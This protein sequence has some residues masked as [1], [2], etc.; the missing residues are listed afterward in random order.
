MTVTRNVSNLSRGIGELLEQRFTGEIVI[1]Q[2]ESRV[3]IYLSKEKLLWVQDKRHFRRRWHRALNKHCAE[4][5]STQALAL[6][7]ELDNYQQLSQAVARQEIRQNQVQAA[8]AEVATECLFELFI[9]QSIAQKLMWMI[10]QNNRLEDAANLGLSSEETKAIILQADLAGKQ[11]QSADLGDYLPS[12][13]PVIEQEQMYD[14]V[15]IPIP[16]SYLQGQHTLWDIAAKMH[17]SIILIARSLVN[18]EK[19]NIIRFQQIPDLRETT[20]GKTFTSLLPSQPNS[21]DDANLTAANPDRN[22]VVANQGTNPAKLNFDPHK[23]IIACIDDSPV[24]AHSVKKIL[25]SVGYQSMIISEPMAGMG[26]LAKYRPNLILLDLLMPTVSGYSVCKFL[27]ETSLFKTTPII[28][29]TSKDTIVDRTRAKLAGA[30][31]FL[32]KPPEPQ[33]LLQVIRLHLID[34][35]WG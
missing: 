15:E 17:T 4:H 19:Q 31:D 26:L 16:K 18:L 24:L 14:A 21:R 7:K 32:T 20:N 8:I 10:E 1:S 6:L 28:I 5:Q 34:I 30:T 3:S 11:W 2:Q 23:P 25:A 35:P 27:R 33:E 22:R 12:L 9:Q 29:L 13:S